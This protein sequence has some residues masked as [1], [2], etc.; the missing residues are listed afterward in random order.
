MSAELSRCHAYPRD[1]RPGLSRR[2]P[3]T[4]RHLRGGAADGTGHRSDVLPRQQREV[5]EDLKGHG[6]V[7]EVI[8]TTDRTCARVPTSRRAPCSAPHNPPPPH[9]KGGGICL[10][11]SW[12]LV[13]L[14][15]E[16]GS[17]KE[18]GVGWDPP[19]PRV[20]LWPPPKARRK[21]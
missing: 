1:Q 10:F 18:G 21:F 20:P 5:D 2:G 9:Y 19:P 15:G 11:K 3:G 13:Q 12:T 16:G 7:A 14:S 17:E 4:G 8:C 6:R